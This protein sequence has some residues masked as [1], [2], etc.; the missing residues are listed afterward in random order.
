MKYLP[1]VAG[2]ISTVCMIVLCRLTGQ[3]I[4]SFL[5][6]AAVGFISGMIGLLLLLRKESNHS[7]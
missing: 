3:I 2:L 5:V 6:S 7:K 4:M 1:Y